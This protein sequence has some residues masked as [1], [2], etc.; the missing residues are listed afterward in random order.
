MKLQTQLLLAV[1]FC[2]LLLTG[3]GG[4][5]STSGSTTSW[6]SVGVTSG[7]RQVTVNWSK[8][9][10]KATGTAT[11]NLYWS[12]SPG[13]T[14][15][16]G[17]KLAAVASPYIHTGLTND[18]MYYYVVTEVVDNKEGSE[19]LEVATMPKAV[20]PLAP[21]G[22]T[23]A[24]QNGAVQIKIDRTGAATTTKFNLY[25]SKSADMK[26]ATKISNAFGSLSTFQHTALTN[27]TTLY[28]GVTAEGPEGESAMSKIVAAMPLADISATNYQV[29]VSP[30]RIAAPNA[31]TAVA[32]NQLTTLGWNMPGSQLPTVFDPSAT[33]TMTPVISAYTI[34]WATTP[35]T[36]LDAVNKITVPVSP[37]AKVKLPMS[38]THNTG[39]VNGTAYYYRITAVA[40]ADA[41]GNSL[42]TADGKSLTF[43]SQASSLVMVVPE[44]KAPVAP[45]G[46]NAT[47]GSQKITLGWAKSSTAN[48]TYNV[49]YSSSA[50]ATPEDLVRPAHLITTTSAVT[51]THSGLQNGA[52]YYYVV[53]AKAD[54]E[55]APSAL[56][57]V[58]LW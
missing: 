4:G 2:M 8:L 49:Y 5:G 42:K 45:A 3:C 56:I 58:N 20:V 51:Y 29:D 43:E 35:F 1:T 10:A 57:V 6:A 41:N 14:K 28:Y 39:L 19:S 30:A 15:S 32:G 37:T 24:P 55:S 13:V 9:T 18:A 53:T 36:G 25:W 31:V 54:G 17:N 34:Y 21:V 7:S 22:L 12:A 16:N 11:Y 33:P 52:S 47:S 27:G 46:F 40:D 38:Y 44:A 26:N 48:T 50:P 23:V